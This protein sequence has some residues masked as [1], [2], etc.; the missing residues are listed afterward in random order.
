MPSFPE[1]QETPDYPPVD[2]ATR[3]GGREGRAGL[4]L[5]V[6]A[7][8]IVGMAGALG[9]ARDGAS[10]AGEGAEVIARVGE[11]AV[12]RQAFDA[13]LAATLGDTEDPGSA[14]AELKSRVLD[15][16]LDEELLM[17]AAS[18]EGLSEPPAASPDQAASRALLM[19][20][21]KE[22]VILNG[23]SVSEEEIRTYFDLHLAEF[24]RPARVVFRQILMD[25]GEEVKQ[26]RTELFRNP[27]RFEELAQAHSLAPDGGR[28]Q[29]LEEELL[30]EAILEAVSRLQDG[31]VSDVVQSP[32]GYFILRLEARQPE[33]APSF[34]E[35]RGQIELKLLRDKSESRYREFVT[36]LEE[37]TRMEILKDKLDFAYTG[38]HRS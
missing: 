21:Y 19:K 23:V 36:S 35:A 5:V 7:V 3:R 37:A 4:P 26:V 33:Q 30:P 17:A 8:W 12:T 11:R 14:G 2:C 27:D 1:Y 15:Q 24:Q 34:Q 13:Y 38:R 22:K 10:S 20:Q 16:Y 31:E 29:A 9:C 32:E 6:A 28:P 25:S 18:K